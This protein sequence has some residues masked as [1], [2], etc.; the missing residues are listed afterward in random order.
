MSDGA[1]AERPRYGPAGRPHDE[2]NGGPVPS[3]DGRLD[4]H[5]VDGLSVDAGRLWGAAGDGVRT[6]LTDRPASLGRPAAVSVTS[7]V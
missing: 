6:E 5:G 4:G 3:D 2:C 1:A 7:S